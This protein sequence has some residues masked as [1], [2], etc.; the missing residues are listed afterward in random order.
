M[1]MILIMILIIMISMMIMRKGKIMIM[2]MTIYIGMMQLFGVYFFLLLQKEY[3]PIL[4]WSVRIVKLCPN[5]LKLFSIIF[6]LFSYTF[7]TWNE[8]S[9]PAKLVKYHFP[10]FIKVFE[11]PSAYM[12]VCLFS[13]LS[14]LNIWGQY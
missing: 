8:M 12:F 3:F 9:S 5:A 2:M 14:N 1:I 6:Q 7:Q 11:H 4:K 13:C 10:G